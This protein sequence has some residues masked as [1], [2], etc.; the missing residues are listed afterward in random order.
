MRTDVNMD[1]ISIKSTI[2]SIISAIP[3][4]SLSS[5][6]LAGITAKLQAATAPEE[7][8]QPSQ[9]P[10]QEPQQEQPLAEID[11][12]E[13]KSNTLRDSIVIDVIKNAVYHKNYD[14]AS[15]FSNENIS[16]DA[17][18]AMHVYLVQNMH[19]TEFMNYIKDIFINSTVVLTHNPNSYS[20]LDTPGQEF[21]TILS[22]LDPENI[23]PRDTYPLNEAQKNQIFKKLNKI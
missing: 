5:S 19:D 6:D 17:L 20:E 12:P 3:K 11:S 2:N 14:N 7:A 16:L 4:G 23:K 21:Y 18:E 22:K 8:Q 9:E 10:A 1:S 15:N 13:G